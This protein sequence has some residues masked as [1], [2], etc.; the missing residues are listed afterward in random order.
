MPFSRTKPSTIKHI[1][2]AAK[3]KRPVTVLRELDDIKGGVVQA[4]SGGDLPRNHQQVYN[5]KHSAK[6]K[7]EVPIM[8]LGSSDSLAQVMYM[9]KQ[10]ID[11]SE[12]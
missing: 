11:C 12:A 8:P 10:G 4:N 7:K 2:D 3:T 9:C 6:V 1:K 5:F